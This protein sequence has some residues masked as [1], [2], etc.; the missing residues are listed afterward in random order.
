MKESCETLREAFGELVREFSIE[1]FD[2]PVRVRSYLRDLLAEHSEER[3]K[4]EFLENAGG[5][6]SLLDALNAESEEQRAVLL[7]TAKRIQRDSL[8]TEECAIGI[9]E[10]FA[11]AIGYD[12]SAMKI[13]RRSS[14]VPL[15]KEVS[16][17]SKVSFQSPEVSAYLQMGRDA[18]KSRDW[19]RAS[20]FFS[21]AIGLDEKC[22]EAYL[23]DYL[24]RNHVPELEELD[25]STAYFG[26]LGW[27][28]TVEYADD[29]LKSRIQEMSNKWAKD[30]EQCAVRFE[31]ARKRTQ[32][33]RQMIAAN[34]SGYIALKSDGTA[35]C[36][37]SDNRKVFLG[38]NEIVAVTAG[39]N[40][41]FGDLFIGIRADGSVR[42]AT[43]SLWHVKS[44]DPE[45]VFS[46][47]IRKVKQVFIA[48]DHIVTW[49]L[50]GTLVAIGSN[51]YGECEIKDWHDLKSVAAGTGFTAA[52]TQDG[53]ILLA[54]EIEKHDEIPKWNDVCELIAHQDE[55][56]GLDKYGRVLSNYSAYDEFNIMSG[57]IGVTGS[58]LDRHYLASDG[59]VFYMGWNADKVSVGLRLHG[60]TAFAE[61]DNCEFGIGIDEY[62]NLIALQ[63]DLDGERVKT[64]LDFDCRHD[65]RLFTELGC[66]DKEHN[67]L[68]HKSEREEWN[69]AFKTNRSVRGLIACNSTAVAAVRS[70]G[71]LFFLEKEEFA[72]RWAQARY[73]TRLIEIT[74]SDELIAGLRDDGTVLLVDGLGK[75]ITE[76]VTDWREII[77]IQ[78]DNK[79]LVGL[80]KDGKVSSYGCYGQ[81]E[82]KT[83]TWTQVVRLYSGCGYIAGLCKNGSIFYAR[84]DGETQLQKLR[85]PL[86]ILQMADGVPIYRTKDHEIINA[87]DCDLNMTNIIQFHGRHCFLRNDS[88]TYLCSDGSFFWN[89]QKQEYIQHNYI[90]NEDH[91]HDEFLAFALDDVNTQRI[92]V[93]RFGHLAVWGMDLTEE[94]KRRLS[95]CHLFEGSNA[96]KLDKERKEHFDCAEKMTKMYHAM[97]YREEEEIKLARAEI[98][99]EIEKENDRLHWAES[100]RDM[101]MLS[102]FRFLKR[103]EIE[104]LN[105]VIHQCQERISRL[106]SENPEDRRI[107]GPFPIDDR[108]NRFEIECRTCGS[109]SHLVCVGIDSYDSPVAYCDQCLMK[110]NRYC[111]VCGE[112]DLTGDQ[113]GIYTSQDT[114]VCGS[115]RQRAQGKKAIIGSVIGRCCSC[116]RERV[117][118]WLCEEELL[119]ESCKI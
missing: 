76:E 67:S 91:K 10:S 16:V 65:D 110:Q 73:W 18:Q 2:E 51:Q 56:I 106:Q 29:A 75:D 8:I 59:T 57:I 108:K 114:Y 49:L 82:Y 52:L 86:S 61:P 103:K 32:R 35:F 95:E 77:Q 118:L 9:C 58:K 30:W 45:K 7:S 63:K 66:I 46:K 105:S 102:P 17:Q 74:M 96:E 38:W 27:Q 87:D 112:F 55:L 80:N 28:R 116:R 68:E 90:F 64:I 97:Q 41:E 70:N 104:G 81:T 48:Q 83:D 107:K 11:Q 71:T 60:M 99:Q 22:A 25:A 92:A 69:K 72:F 88:A 26:D 34:K 47:R 23:G 5:M 19:E 78:I 3:K 113:R 36:V 115:C 101:L 98:H 89:G 43:V 119:C 85:S 109:M 50:D 12:I 24:S 84:R 39:T 62:G 14:K 54:G 4:Y 15:R 1:I 94:Q 111:A 100:E 37:L 42:V 33:A 31:K 44:L 53:H 93:T 79:T 40:E 13:E 21:K 6:Q 117:P 20:S